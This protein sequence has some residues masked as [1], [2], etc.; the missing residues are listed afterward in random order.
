MLFGKPSKEKLIQIINEIPDDIYY[1]LDQ[2]KLK[3]QGYLN[4]EDF[5][6]Y[7]V[8]RIFAYIGNE[9]GYESFVDNEKLI[10]IISYN[11]LKNVLD[12]DEFYGL[13]VSTFKQGKV[14]LTEER[15]YQLIK[16][17][18]LIDAMGGVEKAKEKALRAR[19]V[20]G[21]LE[22]IKQFHGIGNRYGM[23][24]R[25]DT[26]HEDFHDQML[27]TPQISSISKVMGFDFENE[28]Q[29]IYFYKNISNITGLALWDLDRLINEYSNIFL[30]KLV[31]F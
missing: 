28:S 22:F 11:S 6:W 15:A 5:L 24:L 20:K 7:C 23:K 12:S 31:T 17:Y 3:G 25:M 14:E 21:K 9:K 4:R 2:L 16:N 1:R 19:G 8:V 30:N 26:Y 27:I 10:N 18:E 13:L 29:E